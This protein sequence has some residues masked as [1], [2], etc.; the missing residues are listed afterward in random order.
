MPLPLEMGRGIFL[1]GLARQ[2]DDEGAAPARGVAHME[3]PAERSHRVEAQ[4]EAESHGTPVRVVLHERTENPVLDPRRQSA[5][6]VLDLDRDPIP[7]RSDPQE[8]VSAGPRERERVL[9]DVRDCRGEELTIA[10]DMDAGLDW[11]HNEL[12]ALLPGLEHR[13]GPQLRD[14]RTDLDR[15]PH[16]RAARFEPYL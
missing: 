3:L 6:F 8:H 12:A 7:R 4:G 2:V 5:A 9:E 13:L 16:G 11:L 14:E 10:R 1:S 15:L